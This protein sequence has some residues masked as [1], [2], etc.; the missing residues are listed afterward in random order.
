MI[1]LVRT[2]LQRPLTFVVMAIAILILGVLATLRMPVDI[3]PNIRVPVIAISWTFA[4][5]SAEEMSGR[6]IT[7]YERLLTT[8]VS[9]IE[10]LESQSMQGIGVVRVFFQPGADIRTALAQVTSISQVVVR[11]LPPGINPPLIINYDASTVPILQLA[12]AGKGIPE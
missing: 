5:L 11:Q 12:L 10:H 9:D 3:F 4:G 2:A 8:G 1:G 7:I 6:I